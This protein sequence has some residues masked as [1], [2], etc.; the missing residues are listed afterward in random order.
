MEDRRALVIAFFVAVTVLAAGA[1]TYFMRGGAPEDAPQLGAA[2]PLAAP[3]RVEDQRVAA[4]DATP[5]P[6]VTPEPQDTASAVGMLRVAPPS[7]D[8]V[9]VDPRGTAT[10]AG[11]GAP[12]AAAI[13][14]VDGAPLEEAAID[15]GGEWV[16]ILDEPLPAGAVELALLMRLPTGQEVRSE[17]VVVVSVPE[18]R[19]ARPLVVLGS[20]GGASE[21]LQSPLGDSGQPLALLAVD[22][23]D[24]GGVIFSGRAEPNV[25][26]RV[27]ADRVQLGDARADSL[28]R[29]SLVASSA[30]APGIYNLQ[31]DQLDDL[32]RV[33]AVIAVPFKRESPE[34]LA[35]I[36]PRTVVVQPGNSLWRIARRLYGSGWQYTVIYEANE[37]QIRDPNLIYPGQV[38]DLPEE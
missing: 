16:L 19:D 21:V 2:T 30:L 8:I 27:L 34:A 14:L 29:W 28:G 15:N 5:T 33:T 6:D 7:F 11:R 13:L 25:T 38:F 31:I 32:G 3:E 10:I 1:A 35:E 22:Y 20:P 36:G 9:R 37:Q 24:A 4:I 12:G 23:D 18:S 26:V 17:Q